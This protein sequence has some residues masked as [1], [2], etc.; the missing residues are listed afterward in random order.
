MDLYESMRLGGG[1]RSQDL[2]CSREW[3]ASVSTRHLI[4]LLSGPRCADTLSSFCVSFS[5][6]YPITLIEKYLDSTRSKS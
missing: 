5:F 4:F 2:F 6:F 1:V 3:A